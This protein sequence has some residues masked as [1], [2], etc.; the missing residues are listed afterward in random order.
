MFEGFVDEAVLLGPVTLRVRHALNATPPPDAPTFLLLHGHPRT[1][2]TWHRV[3]AALRDLGHSVVCPDLRGYGRSSAP[4]TD[5][6]HRPYSKRAMASDLVGLADYLGLGPLIVVGHDRGAY[7]ALRLALDHPDRV[8]R[9][10]ILD[11]VPLCEALDRTDARFATW[12]W[13]WFFFA[14]PDK[15]EQAILAD[16]EA[17]YGAGPEL[18]ARMGAEA[19]AEYLAAITD[20]AT[21]TAMLEDYRAGLGID[22]E[23]EAADRAAGTKLTCPVLAL[24]ATHDDLADL[25]GDPLAIWARWTHHLQGHDINSGHHMAEDGPHELVETLT[26]FT[27][28]RAGGQVSKSA[29]S[30]D[31]RNA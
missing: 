10:A 29:D 25:Y 9:L 30:D 20:P 11:A 12:W 3:A 21:V 22:Y 14:Q 5:A 13:H 18:E 26:D 16:P 1:S 17:W 19:Y 7:V 24:W 4:P 23:D 8:E 2:A 28:Q 6:Q 15:P 27:D 31:R